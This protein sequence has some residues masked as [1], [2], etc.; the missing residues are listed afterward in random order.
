MRLDA[1]GVG[2]F[3]RLLDLPPEVQDWVDWGRGDFVG[4]SSAS[5]LVRLR[6]HE[7]QRLVADAILSDRLTS[8]EVRQVVQLRDRS[9]RAVPDC[10]REVVGMRPVVERRFVFMGAIADEDMVAALGNLAQSERDK[11]LAGGIDAVGLRGAS[12]RL[13]TR[14]FTLVGGEDFGE[15]MAH[16]GRGTIE[17]LVRDHLQESIESGSS[18]G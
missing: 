18:A 3:L 11:I 10:I 9:G 16:V 17:G 13:G 8:K 5:E 1:S 6:D 14:I 15:S 12:G 4:F 2:R 7:E